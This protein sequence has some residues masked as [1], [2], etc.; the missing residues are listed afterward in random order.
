MLMVLSVSVGTFNVERHSGERDGTTS[1][2]GYKQPVTCCS[3]VN[4]D[5]KKYLCYFNLFSV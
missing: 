1:P 2:L 4:E 5:K 3:G